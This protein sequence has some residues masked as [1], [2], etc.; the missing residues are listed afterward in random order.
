MSRCLK[1]LTPGPLPEAIS[2][3]QL[4]FTGSADP[5]CLCVR[6]C[7]GLNDKDKILLYICA[8]IFVIVSA[9]LSMQGCCKGLDSNAAL[10]LHVDEFPCSCKIQ[11]KTIM[12]SG[13]KRSLTPLC[14]FGL[15][16]SS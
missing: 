16:L 11:L 14:S 12:E 8:N 2:A 15:I 10:C 6:L 1:V 9:L 5:F 4:A 7:P 13:G 3:Q